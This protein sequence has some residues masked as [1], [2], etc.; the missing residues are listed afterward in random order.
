MA[1]MLA[2]GLIEKVVTKTN[3]K[4]GEVTASI[5]IR[6]PSFKTEMSIGKAPMSFT[7]AKSYPIGKELMLWC[8]VGAMREG[9][10]LYFTYDDVYKGD[11]FEK[12]KQIQAILAK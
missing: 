7:D 2:A 11:E 10:R 1:R 3:E 12:A 9:G 4:T 8:T 6:D 5:V